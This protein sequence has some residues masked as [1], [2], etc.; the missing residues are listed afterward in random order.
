LVLCRPYLVLG[1]L[2]GLPV[3][4]DA[5]EAPVDAFPEPRQRKR[6]DQ[7]EED[8]HKRVEAVGDLIRLL[9]VPVPGAKSH[10]HRHNHERNEID[11]TMGVL[12]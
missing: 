3:L 6:L 8:L 4:L 7:D 12:R 2:L 10:T 1:Q 5:A 11:G 9:L